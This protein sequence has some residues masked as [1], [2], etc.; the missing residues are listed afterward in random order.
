M[1][2]FAQFAFVESK[3]VRRIKT[4]DTPAAQAAAA[5]IVERKATLEWRPALDAIEFR[6]QR[7][8]L[9]QACT[10]NRNPGKFL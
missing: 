4:S 10:T 3:R 8:R 2:Q 7:F 9:R 1:N 5:L 6:C